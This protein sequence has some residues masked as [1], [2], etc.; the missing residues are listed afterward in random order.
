LQIERV[1]MGIEALRSEDRLHL[2]GCSQCS[3]ALQA[4]AARELRL[5]E[6]MEWRVAPVLAER[7]PT[8]RGAFVWRP[9]AVAA[10]A[11]LLVTTAVFWK[12]QAE[13]PEPSRATQIY[14]AMA[15]ESLALAPGFREPQMVEPA[16]AAGS[17]S[18][19]GRDVLVETGELVMVE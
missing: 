14:R 11:L 17:H 19:I 4:E 8:N 13:L 2:S 5:Y 3:E 15:P 18:M 16:H 9:A 1:V 6:A 7:R 12:Q 10:A